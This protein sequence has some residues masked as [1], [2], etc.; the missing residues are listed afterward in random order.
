MR[1]TKLQ[2]Q[3]LVAIGQSD[4]AQFFYWTGGT[5]LS[6]HYL[7]HR[8]SEDLDFFSDDLIQE[9]VVLMNMR[10]IK[11]SLK[12]TRLNQRTHL[13]RQQYELQKGNEK[14]KLEFVYFPFPA[15]SKPKKVAPWPV[16][17]AALKDI[18]VNKIFALYERG[19]PKDAV[20]LYYI[21][22]RETWSIQQLT[23]LASKKFDI[24][25]DQAKL[26]S[27]AFTAAAQ[28]TTIK[29]LLFK[30]KNLAKLKDSI[31]LLFSLPGT[32]YLSTRLV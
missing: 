8:G 6:A 5:L 1:L 19:E 13:N 7:H 23:R 10:Q 25:I 11:H 3:L 26:A 31:E 12:L 18:A 22:K 28:L 9:E 24:E 4:L 32:K 29:P 17:V 2:N 27:Q 21:N 16:R 15:V 20:D 14:L 30:E